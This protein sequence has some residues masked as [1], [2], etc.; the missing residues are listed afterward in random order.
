VW[1]VANGSLTSGQGT[2]TVTFT[3]GA[4]GVTDILVVDFSAL[5]LPVLAS[6]EV[7]GQ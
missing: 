1:A 2:A 7:A 5:G 6:Q 3:M 4:S